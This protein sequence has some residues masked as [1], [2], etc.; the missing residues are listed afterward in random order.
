M[1]SWKPTP[2]RKRK[3]TR[4]ALLRIYRALHK[5]YG[6]RHWWPAETPFE[7]MVGAVL[8]QN[9]AWRNVEKAIVNLKENRQLSPKALRK[10]PRKKL[11]ALIRPAGYFNVK[12]KRLKS[13]VDF[14]WKRFGASPPRMQRIPKNRLRQELLEVNGVG[15]ETAD[16]ILLY[17]AGKPSFVVDAYTRRLLGRHGFIRGDETY[18]EIQKTFESNLPE[19]VPLYNDFHAQI[20]EVGK[21]FCRTVARCEACPLKRFL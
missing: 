11:A 14:F 18:A 1:K 9:T 5:Q 7:V 12:A 2:S 17:A 21:D 19:S 20:V 3:P 4:Q 10:I 16:S 8:T 6:D 15:E 13:L